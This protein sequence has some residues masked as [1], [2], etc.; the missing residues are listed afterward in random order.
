MD[1]TLVQRV[2]NLQIYISISNYF[3]I[4]EFFVKHTKKQILGNFSSEKCLR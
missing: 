2:Q 1:I 3:Y 4:K